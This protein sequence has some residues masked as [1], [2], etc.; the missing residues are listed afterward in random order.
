[1]QFD[2][3]II[4]S[5]L[6]GLT[7]SIYASRYKMA[8]VVIGKL[9]GGTITLAHK[10]EN[11]PGFT[12]ITGMELARN[13]IMQVKALGAEILPDEVVKV[14]VVEASGKIPHFF[15]VAT[16][17]GG[18]FEAQTL[19]A[20]TGTERRQLGVPGEKE[21]LGKGVSY[22][23]HCDA[24]FF[25]GKTVAIVGG[26]DAA[27][28]G[29]IHLSGFGQRVYIIYRKSELRAEPIWVEEALNNPKVEVIYNT[30]V[31]EILGDGN[32]VTG[33]K[34]DNPYKELTQL[35][36]DGV[37][38]EIGGVPASSFLLPLGVELD[39][40]GYVKV[41][42]KMETNVSGVFAAGDFT[43]QSLVLQQAITACAQGAIAA[44]S[45]FKYL[46]GKK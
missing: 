18:E 40:N 23:T 32:K 36:L 41:N 16:E 28:G 12:S 15:S 33:V 27:V 2:T 26:S 14:K 39:E 46:R 42:E 3:I 35:P 22:C 9:P 19:I 10:V 7:A 30:N 34:L 4:G 6:A 44:S 45:A 21:Y 43:A 5:G 37:F 8:N 25:K 38:I 13:V 17:K 11:F 20:T 31:L 24:P 1:M 29:A